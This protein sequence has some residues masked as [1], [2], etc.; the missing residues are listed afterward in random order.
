MRS[1]YETCGEFN[2]RNLTAIAKTTLPD[3]KGLICKYVKYYNISTNSE[4]AI[5]G[6]MED[7]SGNLDL[8][9]SKDPKVDTLVG[10]QPIDLQNIE[11]K[12]AKRDFKNLNETD[13]VY[14]LCWHD[15]SFNE[16]KLELFLSNGTEPSEL[17]M[18]LRSQNKVEEN[19]NIKNVFKLLEPMK[20]NGGILTYNGS[21]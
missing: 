21:C 2:I 11:H 20:G 7:N 9:F 10:P 17:L 16:E 4:Y 15:D 6:V 12:F 5:F 14:L 3:S 19:Q 1:V 8:T 18:I 13:T